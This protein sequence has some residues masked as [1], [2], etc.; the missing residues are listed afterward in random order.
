MQ[1]MTDLRLTAPAS[2]GSTRR[3]LNN[4]TLDEAPPRSPVWLTQP[5]TLQIGAELGRGNFGVVRE[6]TWRTTTVAVKVLFN[7]VS[8]DN[9][10][11]F[12]A[13]V[14]IMAQLHHPNIVQFLGYAFTPELTLVRPIR[15]IQNE[16]T[17]PRS[18]L[19]VVCLFNDSIVRVAHTPQRARPAT[20]H[21]RDRWRAQI[22]ELFPNGSVED[23][24][25]KNKPG[26]RSTRDVV[27]MLD[28]MGQVT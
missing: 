19:F 3:R 8:E 17:M 5:Y 2:P 27:R 25:L 10:E 22:I 6:A 16:S 4:K 18:S 11:L 21:R 24:I 26:G 12:E 28:D 14:S 13:E 7:D 1:M 23:I 15:D 20:R 9:Q